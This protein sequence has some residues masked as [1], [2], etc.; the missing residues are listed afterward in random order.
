M[1]SSFHVSLSWNQ[2]P[3]LLRRLFPL[4]LACPVKTASRLHVLDGLGKISSGSTFA[5]CL[6][7]GT[8][9]SVRAQLGMG[10]R[11]FRDSPSSSS[12]SEFSR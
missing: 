3:L 5:C 9:A 11:G 8:S 2:F 6:S 4:P 12:L 7:T 1:S 10:L